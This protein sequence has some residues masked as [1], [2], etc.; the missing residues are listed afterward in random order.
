MVGKQCFVVLTKLDSRLS[1][2]GYNI[3]YY[4]FENH[5]YFAANTRVQYDI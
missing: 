2:L 4:C 1:K 5:S 3:T